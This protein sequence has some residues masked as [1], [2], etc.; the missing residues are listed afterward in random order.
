MSLIENKRVLVVEDTTIAATYLARELSALNAQVVGLARSKEQALEM[1]EKTNPEL[2]LMDIHLADG[3]SGIEAAR[4]IT[5][6]R[7]V[8]VIFT[9]SYS[10]DTTLQ[11]AMSVSPY[12]YVVKPFDVKTIKV[13]CETALKRFALEE[14][15]RTSEKRF[16]VAAEAAKMGVM[17]LDGNGCSFTYTG[18]KSL[19]HQFGASTTIDLDTFLALFD[20][21]DKQDVTDS[22]SQG[23]SLHKTLCIDAENDTWLDIVFSEIDVDNELV[24]IGAVIDVTERQRQS[25][26]LRLSSI[27]FD[28]LAEGVAVLAQ[29]F[30][31]LDCNRAL[32]ELIGVAPERLVGKSL[33]DFGIDPLSIARNRGKKKMLRDKIHLH[34]ARGDEFPALL[35]VTELTQSG[36]A[37]RFVATISDITELTRAE[38]QLE[39]LAFTDSLTGA[40]NRN[41]LKLALNDSVFSDNIQALIFV[42][43]DGFKAINDTHGHDVGD[44]VLCEC[45]MRLKH[46]IRENDTLIRHGG[47][48]FV[49]LVQQ[50]D[51]L[52]KLS[53]RL[54]AAFNDA[55]SVNDLTLTVGASIGVA[56]GIDG[57]GADEL[58]KHADIA[59]Y[60]AKRKGK[61]Q[62]VFYTSAQSDSIE[63]RLYVEQ[64]LLDAIINHELYAA[65]QPIV[66]MSG[67]IVALEALCRWKS[68][69]IGDIHPD[70]FIPIAEETGLINELGL[71]M[72]REVCIASS[73]LK[74]EG[75]GHVKV[76]VNVSILQLNSTELVKQF[77][78]FLDEFA[79]CADDIVLEVTESAMH[80]IGTRRILRELASAG[81]TI[82]VDDFGSG[83]AS[84]SELTEPYTHIVKMDKSLL[85]AENSGETKRVIID[86]LIQ[87]CSRLGKSVLLEGIETQA[88]ANFARQAGCDLM[89]GFLFSRPKTINELLPEIREQLEVTA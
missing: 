67:N 37:E 88:H 21:A 70:S 28:Q 18:A 33:F 63:Y 12:G 16:K 60:E 61:G 76:H 55:I 85:P 10:D 26:K 19:Q 24:N 22:I 74:E 86:T 5:Q 6:Q 17:E 68:Q 4:S 69:E 50:S 14:Q 42:D 43:L 39:S 53:Q 59:M 15:A 66:D 56:E 71:K 29:D 84:I 58:L 1:V 3:S 25:K 11:E 34:D 87:M 23:K 7:A 52:N 72:L 83:Y 36:D 75:L 45:A 82:A 77:M 65:Y 44:E 41:Y 20:D 64:G 32:A 54:L 13:T 48:E 57:K 30:T 73:L 38:K 35:T 89:Q 81:F 80:D 27:I 8:P 49:V 46:S 62:V 2:I 47:D 9:T 79:I 31:V 51:D 78:S 40:G